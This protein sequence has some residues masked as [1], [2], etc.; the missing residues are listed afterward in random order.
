MDIE[1]C[2]SIIKWFVYINFIDMMFWLTGPDDMERLYHS[3][4][5]VVSGGGNVGEDEDVENEAVS[6]SQTE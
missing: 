3:V 2:H 5:L 4:P 6:N 1:S